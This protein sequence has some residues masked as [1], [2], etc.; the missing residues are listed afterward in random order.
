[1]EVA[2]LSVSITGDTTGLL[3]ALESAEEAVK[4][5]RASLGFLSDDMT[6]LI[7]GFSSPAF[8][9][10]KNQNLVFKAAKADLEHYKKSHNMSLE[11]EARAWKGLGEAF[12]YDPLSMRE[13]E[14]GLFNVEK[15]IAAAQGKVLA[16][17]EKALKAKKKANNDAL[18]EYK[19]NSDAWIEYE[20]KVNDMTVE[21]QIKSYTRQKENYNAMVSDMLAT[22]DYSTEEIKKVW[23]SFYRY[24]A[25]VDLKIG[26][27]DKQ[28]K[29]GIYETW[30][31]HAEGWLKIRNLYGDWEESGDSKVKFYNRSIARIGEMYDSGN[32]PWQEYRDDT[33]EATL[34]LY[35]AK[36]EKV[37]DLIAIQGKYIRDTK[38]KFADEENALREKWA[39]EDRNRS[40][41]EVRGDLEIYNGA[42]TRRG[43]DKYKS[44]QKE[45]LRLRREEEM[46]AMEKEHTRVLK[47]LENNYA[48]IEE[49]KK[50]LLGVIEKSGL[51]IESIVS[52]ARIDIG[53]IQNTITSLFNQTISAI[54]NLRLSSN[55]YS[56]NRRINVT[57][58]G[59]REID[60]L[61]NNIIGSIAHGNFY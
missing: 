39:K 58:N 13:V 52:A 33:M 1:M 37:D 27:L 29:H 21:E 42:V 23:D 51:D 22:T 11:E 59:S 47:D 45:M 26:L 54:K 3:S 61:K 30:Q 6:G 15:R 10:V 44:L 18:S 53:A 36:M 32:I 57:A 25:G 43:M 60:A 46:Y 34:N 12:S 50:Y 5:A 40:I 31:H 38:T 2:N 56:D 55:T 49:N 9:G 20:T 14:E 17:Q 35:R 8:V 48:D 7:S 24:A 16:A 19:H 41:G 28:Q 4:D